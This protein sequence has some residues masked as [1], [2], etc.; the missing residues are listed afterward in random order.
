MPTLSLQHRVQRVTAPTVEP[1]SVA[2]AKRHLRVEH[3]ELYEAE[4]EV[5]NTDGTIETFPNNDYI[6]VEIIDDIA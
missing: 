2:D 6:R 1:V 4:F 3:S 5:T